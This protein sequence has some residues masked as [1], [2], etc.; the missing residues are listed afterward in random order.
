M[1]DVSPSHQL[2]GGTV[3]D[4]HDEQD[5]HTY[6]QDSNP[7]QGLL[8]MI[9]AN[10][11]FPPARKRPKLDDNDTRRL[12]YPLDMRRQIKLVLQFTQKPLE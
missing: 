9:P 3:A 4:R 5:K 7:A 2:D 6:Q 11:W 10:E 12:Q 8:G 1:E